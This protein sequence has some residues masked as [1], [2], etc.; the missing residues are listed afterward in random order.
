MY[1]QVCFGVHLLLATCLGKLPAV[2][3]KTTHMIRVGSRTVQIPDMLHLGGSIL[4]SSTPSWGFGRVWLDPSVPISDSGFRVL[5]F[6]VAFIYPSA[7]RKILP[8]VYPCTSR[9]NRMPLYLQTRDT[10]YLPHP[11]HHWQWRI[12]DLWSRIKGNQ[13]GDCMQKFINGVLVAFHSKGEC[14]IL[15]AP[16]RKWT[17]TECQRCL[18]L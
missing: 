13:G 18:A 10:W 9:M 12:N 1:L 6:V 2:R 11:E 14:D 8:Q 16:C 17:S 7:N 3:V 5:L 4:D 15:H